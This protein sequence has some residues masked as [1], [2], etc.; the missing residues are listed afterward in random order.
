MALVSTVV[1]TNYDLL[2][3][4]TP[5]GQA[6]MSCCSQW[7]RGRVS[8]EEASLGP[9]AAA[10]LMVLRMVGPGYEWVI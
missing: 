7:P 2:G 4:G 9:Q 5:G 8:Q 10:P 1:S 6:T 3:P